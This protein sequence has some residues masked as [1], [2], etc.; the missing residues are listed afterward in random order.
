MAATKAQTS[1]KGRKNYGKNV[2]RGTTGERR[3]AKALRN[4]GYQ[5]KISKGSR[6][7]A[8]VIAR[9]GKTTR[10]I[11]VKNLTS[12]TLNSSTVAKRR[13]TGQPFNVPAGRETW[14]YDKKGRCHKF[15]T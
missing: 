14:V 13:V 9:K 6:G 10:R 12:R 5:V 4:Q 8:D 15:R 11:Q 2:E 3:T 7:P 1:R